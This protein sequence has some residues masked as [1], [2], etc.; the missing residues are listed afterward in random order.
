MKAVCRYKH[1]VDKYHFFIVDDEKM[2]FKIKRTNDS[3]RENFLLESTKQVYKKTSLV[4]TTPIKQWKPILFRIANK[5]N[6]LKSYPFYPNQDL[7]LTLDIRT[8]K[9]TQNNTTYMGWTAHVKDIK[10]IEK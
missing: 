6:L 4:Y 10:S 3:Y 5:S 8:M 9:F 7:E 1:A 2:I